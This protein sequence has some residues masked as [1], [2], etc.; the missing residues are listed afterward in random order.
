MR[1]L[2][3]TTSLFGVMRDATGGII[4]V[5]VDSLVDATGGIIN[6]MVWSLEGCVRLYH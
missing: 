3:S 2:V 5:I 4:N 6:V 1:Q